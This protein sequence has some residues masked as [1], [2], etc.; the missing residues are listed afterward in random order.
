MFDWF[1]NIFNKSE[2]AYRLPI[3]PL[4]G[5]LKFRR[6]LD[7]NQVYCLK[8]WEFRCVGLGIETRNSSRNFPQTRS[9]A[10]ELA[11]LKVPPAAPLATHT[12][13]SYQAKRAG[14]SA[15]PALVSGIL[16]L[17]KKY[18]PT[19]PR[20]TGLCSNATYIARP[21]GAEWLIGFLNPMISKLGGSKY[22]IQISRNNIGYL[23]GGLAGTTRRKRG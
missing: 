14:V 19:L 7:T 2:D 9:F 23:F 22:L 17:V 16:R 5:S 10:S 4:V 6:E 11:K 20:I 18:P 8:D 21:T 3:S 13:N 12:M 1:D 15:C